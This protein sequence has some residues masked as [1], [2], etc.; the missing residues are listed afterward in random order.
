M[1]AVVRQKNEKI[2]GSVNK[3]HR[4]RQ[5]LK[6]KNFMLLLIYHKVSLN[7]TCSQ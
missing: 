1:Y 5:M 7:D 2:T 6:G 3:I 4:A